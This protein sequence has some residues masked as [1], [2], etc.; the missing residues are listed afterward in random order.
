M[1]TSLRE[2]IVDI[3]GG[4]P[5]GKSVKAVQTGGPSGG[6]IPHEHLDTPVDYDSLAAL[7]S[8]MGSGGMIVM[9][10]T[11]SMVEVARFFMDFCRTESCGKCVPCRVGTQQMHTLLD[12][13]VEG[14][15]TR[16]DLELLERICNMVKHTS[17]CGLGKSAPN[18]VISTIRY[19]RPEYEERLVGE[20]APLAGVNL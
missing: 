3:G 14:E 18:P 6:C 11:T 17:L 9:D 4:C 5:G 1:G 2:L 15:G 7:G 19:F 8:I 12:R 10:E 20:P 16:A 13:I